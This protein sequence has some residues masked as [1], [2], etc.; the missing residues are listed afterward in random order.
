MIPKI[1]HYCWV[2][3]KPKPDSV[4]QCIA[5][6]KKYCPN[7]EIREWTEHE[8]DMT[9]NTY[10]RQAY[11]SGNWSF[12]VDYMRLWVMY[13]W[14]GIYL[15][16][17]VQVVRSFA[18]LLTLPAF[19][20]FERDTGNGEAPFVNA[21]QGFGA[22]PGNPVIGAMLK[23]YDTL[24]FCLPDGSWNRTPSP[25]YT[26]Q[27]LMGLGL[28]RTSNTIQKL[29]G[30]TIFPTEYFCPKSYMTGQIRRTKHTYSIHHFDGSWCT[31]EEL[32]W[33]LGQWKKAKRERWV[34]YPRGLIQAVFG[35]AA[36][37]RLKAVF[38]R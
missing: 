3:G 11:E 16:T 9:C 24:Q 36:W 27:I 25:R 32:Q 7:F 23:Q 37:N 17:D 6:W 15:D 19:A 5:S 21:G 10:C 26:T 4:Y 30:I 29:D 34:K 18:P 35:E 2:G 12:A 8:F 22:E 33:K 31:E 13:H 38:R 28:D 20:G 1:I 14:G